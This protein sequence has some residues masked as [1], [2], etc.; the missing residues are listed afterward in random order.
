MSEVDFKQ[1]SDDELNCVIVTKRGELRLVHETYRR[2]TDEVQEAENERARRDSPFKVGDR[3][4]DGR[5]IYEITK[6]KS[7]SGRP[8]HYGRKV[9]KNGGLHKTEFL[10]YRNLEKA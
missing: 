2:L 10:L 7:Y 4:N 1:M 6:I 5:N 3:V 9:L 8:T